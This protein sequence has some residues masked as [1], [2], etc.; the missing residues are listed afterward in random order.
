METTATQNTGSRIISTLGVGSGVDMVQLASDLSEARF[1]A[2]KARLEQQSETLDTR[3][4]SAA[5]L[6]GQLTQL[7][8]ALGD[9]VRSGDLAPAATIG[10]SAVAN[11]SVGSGSAPSGTYSLEVTSLA[12]SQTLASKTYASG[13]ATV[14]A[15]TLDINFGTV[16]GANFTADTSQNTLSIAVT[17]DD[18]LETLAAKINQAGGP[19]RAYVATNANGAQLVMKGDEGATG[20]FTIETTP[21]GV[22]RLPGTAAR[23][24]ELDYLN[25]QPSSDTGQLK[26]TAGDAAFLLDG[27][28]M[29]SGSNTVSGLPGGLSLTL[30][31]TN[32]GAPTT[33]GFSDRTANIAGLMSDFV[34][35]LNDITGTLRE[36]AAPLGGELGSDPGARALKRAFA[37]MTTAV[38]MPN[39]V[40]GAPNT[41]GDL[42]LVLGRD[43]TFS[44]DSNRLNAT[45]ATD[46][47]G[48]A[49]MFTTGIHGVYATFDKLARNTASRKDP[50]SLAG[51]EARYNAQSERIEDKLAR[52][53]EQ[54][55]SLRERLTKT[56][57]AADRNVNAS[58]STLSFLQSQIAV[59]NADK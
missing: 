47:E 6:R 14:G 55:E 41:L 24:G 27:V 4:S 25:W 49:A 38:V 46:P 11:V 22:T 17:A 30:K 35:A 7:A 57:A 36:A 59:W 15:G 50:G 39:A 51:S 8:T 3:I 21:S 48:A 58:Q 40:A 2:Q 28:E 12:A 53:A 43:G 13:A 33:I 10:N 26:Q 19:V 54:Q 18:T 32:I 9:R 16:A 20:G 23:A 5:A 1:M 31:Q 34:A 45:L 42:G 29:T 44:L 52:I 56:F 37:S